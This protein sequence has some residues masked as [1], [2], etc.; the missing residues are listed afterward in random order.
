MSKERS[1]FSPG[2]PVPAEFFVGREEQVKLLA[3][4]VQ[5]A[6]V[7]N[8]QYVFITGERGIGKSSLA[9]LVREVAEKEYAFVG[10]QAQLGGAESLGE[11]C[12]RL[13]QSLVAQL[14][15]KNLIDLAKGVFGRYID[16]IDLFGLG[17]EFKKD[18][19]S[20]ESLAGNFLPLLFSVQAQF[21]KAGRKGIILIADD[22]N[23]VAKEANFA[24]FLKSTV[25]QIAVGPK[26]DFPWMFVLVGVP[27]RMADLRAQQPSVDRIFSVIELPLM[28]PGSA[29]SFFEKT[30]SSVGHTCDED[31]LLMLSMTAG[32]YPVFWHEIGDA[33][34]WEDQDE[35]IS[36]EDAVTGIRRAAEAIGRKYLG[37][38]LFEELNSPAYKTILAF[39]AEHG[40]KPFTRAEALQ[41]VAP[42]DEKYFDYFIKKMRAMD[43]I[44]S[45]K[46]KGEYVFTS[47]L[48][49]LY[50]AL[51]RESE[52]ES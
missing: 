33:V 42:K 49:P 48:Y 30:F 50:I 25:D 51:R 17:I 29:R 13:Y 23:G 5:Q 27:E 21:E 35:H 19:Q 46:R 8:S 9:S 18:D 36:L 45:G 47:S 10:A 38:P 31:A 15:D 3:R 32:G 12:R 6:S 52:K 34:Y 40:H 16:G 2:K 4:A 24:H 41:R 11:V 39:V 7:G 28:E 20:R 37:R 26:R 44:R 14:P 22:L 1:P 43:V